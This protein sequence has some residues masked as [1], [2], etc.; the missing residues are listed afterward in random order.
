MLRVFYYSES[1]ISYYYLLLLI[2]PSPRRAGL[3]HLP[4][5][6]L[7]PA[8]P[9]VDEVALNVR[10][11]EDAALAEAAAEEGMDDFIHELE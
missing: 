11:V 8:P 2:F 6:R 3:G 7:E 4:E 1:L 9:G 5:P 10:A